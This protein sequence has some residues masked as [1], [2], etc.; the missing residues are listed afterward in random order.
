VQITNNNSH[1]NGYL[2][3]PHDFSASWSPEGNKIVLER[4]SPDYGRSGIYVINADGSGETLVFQGIANRSMEFSPLAGVAPLNRLAR[5][6][7]KLIEK[8]GF[9]P[10]WGPA[11]N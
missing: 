8:G 3:G 5:S 7:L 2:T 9:S 10:R 4:D 11:S 6:H 1:W